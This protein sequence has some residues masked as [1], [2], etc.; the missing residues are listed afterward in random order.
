MNFSDAFRIY[1]LLNV[2]KNAKNVNNRAM[3]IHSNFESIKLDF[4]RQF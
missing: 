2:A 3:V 1:S 4:L